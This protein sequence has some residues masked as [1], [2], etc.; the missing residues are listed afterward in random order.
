MTDQIVRMKACLNGRRSRADHPAVPVAPAELAASAA[1]AVAAGAEAVHLHTR[2]PDGRES[3]RAADVAAAVTAVR[4]IC[5]GTPVGV[6]T[7]LWITG[8]DP[9][10]RHRAVASWASLSAGERPDFASVNVA[11]PGAL[12]TAAVLAAAG[13]AAEAGVWSVA[14]AAALAAADPGTGWLR[15]M[16]EVIGVPAASAVAVADDILAS[17]DNQGV[18]APRLLHGENQTC[19]PLIARAGALGL[20]ARIG[21]EDTTC[22]PDGA[23]VGGNA[24]LISLAIAVWTTNAAT[25]TA[26]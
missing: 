23:G 13:I 18:A 4:R 26:G 1:E 10:A 19:W 3:L 2:G 25:A 22:G 9:A 14:D 17:L 6:S 20:P 11:E 21:L 8:G 12:E 16:V 7:G 5:P 15:V 24:E